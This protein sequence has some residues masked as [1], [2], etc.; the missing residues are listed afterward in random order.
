MRII[1]AIIILLILILGIT[2][3]SL[4]A[5]PVVVNYYLG[6]S[7]LPLSLLLVLVLGCG[8]LLGILVSIPIWARLKKE[9]YTLSQRI[10]V[11]EK[12]IS[13]FTY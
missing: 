9:N 4:N 13:E 8:A 10:K 12:R 11:A 1:S 5:E 6:S 2:F 7:K 3:A